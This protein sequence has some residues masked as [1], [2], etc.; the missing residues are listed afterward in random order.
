MNVLRYTII[1]VQPI[2]VFHALNAA[3]LPKPLPYPHVR[4]GLNQTRLF[5]S[6]G[7]ILL[8]MALYVIEMCM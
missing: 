5:V 7:P 3:P 6:V 2:N 4:Q 1:Q 8:E